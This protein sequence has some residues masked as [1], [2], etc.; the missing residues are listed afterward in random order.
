MQ[1]A[2]VFGR[3]GAL[4]AEPSRGESRSLECEFKNVSLA[5]CLL[6]SASLNDCSIWKSP[7]NQTGNHSKHTCYF[8]L[9]FYK[10]LYKE[11]YGYSYTKLR[12]LF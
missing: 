4:W 1:F 2:V 10:Q 9:N 12:Y 7:Y 3:Q 6:G 8:L 11:N 5:G